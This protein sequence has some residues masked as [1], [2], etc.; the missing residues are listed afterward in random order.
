M[1]PLCLQYFLQTLTQFKEMNFNTYVNHSE[2]TVKQLQGLL[3]ERNLKTSG[4]KSELIN[5]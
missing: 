4:K 2:L 3:R 1:Y 5:R